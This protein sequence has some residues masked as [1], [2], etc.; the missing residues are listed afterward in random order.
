MQAHD[1]LNNQK[2]LR[3]RFEIVTAEVFNSCW[4]S[5]FYFLIKIYSTQITPFLV[6]PKSPSR[7]FDV[8]SKSDATERV[9]T[10][11]ASFSTLNQFNL[12]SW[13][14]FRCLAS[15]SSAVLTRFTVDGRYFQL[16]LSFLSIFEWWYRYL[17]PKLRETKIIL[18]ISNS[19]W[20]KIKNGYCILNVSLDIT[21]FHC[22]V[23]KP[24]STI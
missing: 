4:N 1:E 8:N 3:R 24:V 5:R 12:S 7:Y 23:S 10:L 15:R 14:N 19:R 18:N 17:K 9:S 6:I 21:R 11:Y 13:G 22:K 16:S 20:N 2:L